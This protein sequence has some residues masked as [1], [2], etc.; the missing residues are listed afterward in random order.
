MMWL[1]LKNITGHLRLLPLCRVSGWICRVSGQWINFLGN[2][3]EVYWAVPQGVRPDVTELP[4]GSGTLWLYATNLDFKLV[5]V[6]H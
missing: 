6:C 1:R 3:P 5:L 4:D 2:A